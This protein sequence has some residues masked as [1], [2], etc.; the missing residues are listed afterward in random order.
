MLFIGVG[1]II[2]WRIKT[3]GVG[4]G[5]GGI[6]TA[7][8]REKQLTVFACLIFFSG[9]LCFI[10][11]KD[12]YFHLSPILKIP[13]YS[14]LGISVSFALTFSVIDLV[15]YVIGFLQGDT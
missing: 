5:V 10:L 7:E 12:W 15:N 8:A 6:G 4:S 9:F 13:L 2:L 11:E 1:L 3:G 14:V